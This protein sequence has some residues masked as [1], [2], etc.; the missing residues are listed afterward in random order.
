MNKLTKYLEV[1]VVAG[2]LLTIGNVAIKAAEPTT[3]PEP[4][5]QTTQTTE[6]A[7]Q[8]EDIQP[9]EVDNRSELDAKIKEAQDLGIDIQT[10][11][12]QQT[13]NQQDLPKTQQELHDYY[14]SQIDALNQVIEQQKQY[15]DEYAKE[16]E[17]AF[18]TVIQDPIYKQDEWSM[19][20][21]KDLVGGDFNKVT[22]I[23]KRPKEAL[24]LETHLAEN[25]YLHKGDYWIYRNV[26]LDS[27]TSNPI[28]MRFDVTK[29]QQ[30]TTTGA[31]ETGE[32]LDALPEI[33]K[34]RLD[35]YN[36][37][38]ALLYDNAQLT[39]K[40]TFLD[41]DDNPIVL[42]KP[43]VIITDVD[44]NQAIKIRDL[45]VKYLKG[46]TLVEKNGLVGNFGAY[47]DSSPDGVHRDAW[48]MYA[49]PA[50][51]HFT[52][53]FYTFS[54]YFYQIYQGVGSETI[55]YTRPDKQFVSWD[56]QNIQLTDLFVL[57]P[58]Q[59]NTST[60]E[61]DAIV[62]SQQSQ[63]QNQSMQTNITT[64]SADV[65]TSSNVSTGVS[66]PW[67]SSLFGCI[68]SS[69]GLASIKKRKK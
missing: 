14:Q 52:Y 38:I 2:A 34:T 36:N 12:N 57:Q 67:M 10:I 44:E 32:N 16:Q 15:N 48:I 64:T 22:V 25:G 43:L 8:N 19:D 55:S 3:Q 47:H 4:I 69:L 63:I 53:T 23:S 26:F 39:L 20:Q 58:E 59:Q 5:T 29:I 65:Q 18:A 27:K 21:L 28:G 33:D 68:V 49:L 41:T 35:F 51:D 24:Q 46:S 54:P 56:G 61:E 50:T 17:K 66:L 42:E 31:K 9:V 62:A 6:T 40:V 37:Q 7:N 60:K 13:V 11:N 45:D 30:N 1:P